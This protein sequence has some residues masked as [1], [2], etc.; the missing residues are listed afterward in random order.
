M[1][2]EAIPVRAPQWVSYPTFCVFVPNTSTLDGSYSL[3]VKFPSL[4]R[5]IFKFGLSFFKMT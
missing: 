3:P 5:V 4:S 1:S 2:D